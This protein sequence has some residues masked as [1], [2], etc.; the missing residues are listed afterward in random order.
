MIKT[1]KSK[2]ESITSTTT[3]THSVNKKVKVVIDYNNFTSSA[4]EFEQDSN[5]IDEMLN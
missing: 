3:L 2:L 5:Q 4:K 1:S